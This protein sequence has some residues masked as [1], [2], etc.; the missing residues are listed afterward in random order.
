MAKTKNERFSGMKGGSPYANSP[1]NAIRDKDAGK[2]PKKKRGNGSIT[3]KK[4]LSKYQLRTQEEFLK[5]RP[6]ETKEQWLFRTRF[7]RIRSEE[8]LALTFEGRKQLEKIAL[9]KSRSQKK[10]IQ[11]RVQ[12]KDFNFLKYYIFIINWAVIKYNIPQSDLELGL[13][14]YDNEHFTKDEFMNKC[15]LFHNTS[16]NIFNRFKKEGYIYETKSTMGDGT[17]KKPTNLYKLTTRFVNILTAI[18][19]RVAYQ[20]HYNFLPA[21]NKPASPELNKMIMEMA[22]ENLDIMNG[23][24]EPDLFLNHNNYHES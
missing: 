8:E 23:K 20:A 18:Y 4:G 10:R 21:E 13:H 1:K 2:K 22:M 17:E 12:A 3:S 16:A 9:Q 11:L 14:L 7:R 19:K 6:G 24:K 5:V 15:L